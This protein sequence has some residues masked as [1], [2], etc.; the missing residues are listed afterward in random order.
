MMPHTTSFGASL[1]LCI[2]ASS[3]RGTSARQP[4]AKALWV[5]RGFE[6]NDAVLTINYSDFV[7]NGDL[8]TLRAA[9]FD[10]RVQRASGL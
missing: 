10:G 6:R 5:R 2:D 1:A 4:A 8:Y 3:S 9:C 7:I